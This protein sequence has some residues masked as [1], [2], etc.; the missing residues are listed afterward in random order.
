MTTAL[1]MGTLIQSLRWV[2]RGGILL[3]HLTHTHTHTHTH[4]HTH[5]PLRTPFSSLDH[6]VYKLSL[7]CMTHINTHT[8]HQNSSTSNPHMSAISHT[9]SYTVTCTHTLV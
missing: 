9:Q 4:Y 8:P 7:I 3:T 1:L 6:C 2:T 5:T